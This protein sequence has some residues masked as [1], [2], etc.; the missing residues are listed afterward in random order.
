MNRIVFKKI[1]ACNVFS[2]RN[3]IELDYTQIQGLTYVYGINKDIPGSKNGVGKSS[4][5]LNALLVA[6]YGKTVANINNEFIPNRQA[7]WNDPMYIELELTKDFTDNY[8]IVVDIKS[9]KKRDKAA[10]K[11]TVECNGI[12]VTKSTRNETLAFI[13]NEIIGCSFELF[14]NTVAISSSNIVNFFQMPKAM[15]NQYLQDI[16]SLDAIGK[17][18]EVA[19]DKLTEIK[20]TLKS[21][22]DKLFYCSKNL[23]SVKAQQ[24]NWIE[25]HN[26][27]IESIK[28]KLQS[29]EA[30]FQEQVNKIDKP[31]AYEQKLKAIEKYSEYKEKKSEIESK[32]KE[33]QKQAIT[34]KSEIKTS[35]LL[36]NKNQELLNSLCK[37]CKEVV[38]KLFHLDEAQNNIQNNNEILEEIKGKQAKL[39]NSL[40]KITDLLSRISEARFEIKDYNN[41][42][43]LIEQEQKF[44]ADNIELFKKNLDKA[45]NKENPFN[46]LITKSEQE[47]K[48]VE[49]KINKVSKMQQ[50]YGAAKQIFSDEGVKQFIIGDIIDALNNHIKTYLMKMGAEF[51]VYFDNNLYYEFITNT[52]PCEYFSFS[53]GERRRLDLA[54]LFAFRDI[55]SINSVQTNLLVCDEILDANIDSFALQAIVQILKNKSKLDGQSI[56]VISHRESLEESDELFDHKIRVEKEQGETNLYLEN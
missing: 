39:Q 19:T 37:D 44:I 50:Y 29:E 33:N 42:L 41:K 34:L 23:E 54:V 10:L 17:S 53:A 16:F 25:E 4:L 28:R 12:D 13:E 18:Y 49:T 22:T 36:I 15:K 2:I 51:T 48:D 6:L 1:R 26:Q 24:E 35:Q 3:E 38:T 8:K 32:I 9:C 5:C 52:G 30:K 20:K 14:K 43:K 21:F 31:K 47:Q 45:L 55:M 40:N 11:F 56:M 46:E 7:A 27:E